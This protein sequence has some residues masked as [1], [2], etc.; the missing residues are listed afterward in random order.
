[1]AE[2]NN[3]SILFDN[4]HLVEYTSYNTTELNYQ[5][6][7]IYWIGKLIIKYWFPTTGPLGIIGDLLCLIIMLLPTNRKLVTATYLAIIA[8]NDAFVVAF[9]Y[10]WVWYHDY[11][12][13]KWNSLEC[14]LWMHVSISSTQAGAL[15]LLLMT[16]D[17]FYVIK[18]PLKTS[19]HSSMKRI[20]IGVPFIY[21]GTILF[22]FCAYF[23]FEAEKN[24]CE[25]SSEQT[26]Y[27][28][29]YW[30]VTFFTS[31]YNKFSLK[32]LCIP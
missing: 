18:N 19:V 13:L 15:I 26:W 7:V 16:Y 32:K 11:Y 30:F 29:G 6:L 9:T 8:V 27:V 23:G 5:Y 22:N 14:K 31:E 12:E 4:N 10:S 20:K 24:T 2:E 17:K 1:M 21:T 28:L 3:T 25:A